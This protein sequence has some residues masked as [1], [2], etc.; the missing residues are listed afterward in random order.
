MDLPAELLTESQLKDCNAKVAEVNRKC[1]VYEDEKRR[2][3]D[4]KRK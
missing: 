4:A 2:D 3:K 1:A